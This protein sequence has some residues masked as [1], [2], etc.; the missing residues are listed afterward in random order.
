MRLKQ[1]INERGN[2][3]NAISSDWISKKKM[4][5]GQKKKLNTQIYKILKPTYFK[6][7]PL[8]PIFDMLE[9]NGVIVIQEDNTPWS[10][11]LVGGVKR[12]EYVNFALAWKDEMEMMHGLKAYKAIPNAMLSLSYYKMESGNYEVLGYIPS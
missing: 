11:F 8:D 10:G 12:T 5:A 1:F 6:S 7:I 2:P 4:K 3:L 9:K